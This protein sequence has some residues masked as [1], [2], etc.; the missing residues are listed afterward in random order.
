MTRPFLLAQVSDPHVTAAGTLCRGVDTIAMLRRCVA[1][2][3][4]MPPRPDAVA[5][6]GDLTDSG[7]EEQ[8]AM[9][10]ELLAP[11]DVPLYLIPGNHDDRDVL[12]AAFADRA[13]LR[14]SPRFIQYAIEDHALRIVALDTVMGESG[15]ELCEARLE[16]LDR[17]LAAAPERATVVLMHHP[18][19]RTFVAGL[20]AS[21]LRD[22]APFAAVIAR[23]P[24]VEAILCG[25]VHRPIEV[26]FAG[27]RASTS[28]SCAHQIALDLTP[29]APLRALMEPPA[30]R[31]H[32]YSAAT[33]L[34]SHTVYVGE[35]AAPRAGNLR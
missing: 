33:G 13:Y 7:R 10:R 3:T 4:S 27:T 2:L 30:Y 31:L 22:P 11:F 28:P 24:Q 34:V 15:G 32:A 35:F 26:R 9:L 17:T 8:Y 21:A 18:P 14:Q 19:F 1:Q 12:R 5:I 20:D 25:H 6:T 29:G 16:W 23:H